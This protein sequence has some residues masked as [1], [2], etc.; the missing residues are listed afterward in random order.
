MRL[1][2]LFIKLKSIIKETYFE[3]MEA[4]KWAV[5]TEQRGIPEEFFQQCTASCQKK[6]RKFIRLERVITLMEKPCSL[7]FVN[8]LWHQFRHFSGSPP[9]YVYIYIYAHTSIYPSIFQGQSSWC[10]K[11]WI[12]ASNP[13]RTITLELI[14]LV[15]FGWVLWH[16]NHCRL[17]NAKSCFYKYILNIWLVNT[18]FDRFL[19]EPELIH[20]YSVKWFQVFL[21]NTNIFI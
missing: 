17:F 1:F 8:C 13:N 12:T 5:T 15:W 21:P 18:F 11:Y 6:M 14:P 2:N 4:E 7:L 9:V 3:G 20:L 10:L 19:N 16:I